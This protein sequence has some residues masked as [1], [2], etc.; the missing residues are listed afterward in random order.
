MRALY[1]TLL[2][3]L[4]TPLY[5]VRANA[6]SIHNMSGIAADFHGEE[7]G[8]C[9]KEWIADGEVKSCPGNNRGCRNET[10]VYIVDLADGYTAAYF[11]IQKP[12]DGSHICSIKPPVKVTAHGD[13]YAYKDRVEV[14]DDNGVLLYKGP[15][16]ARVC[17][18]SGSPSVTF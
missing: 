5:S 10:S 4:T 17:T 8:P 7:C 16:E 2:F 13:V 3:C 12:Q 18:G 6:Y 14:T 15:W 11:G 1:I 9:F